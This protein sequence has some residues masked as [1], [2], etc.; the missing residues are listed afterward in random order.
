MFFDLDLPVGD[1][2]DPRSTAERLLMLQKC[3]FELKEKQYIC[4][5]VLNIVSNLL[6]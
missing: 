2:P 3:V 4:V 1:K 5:C 6:Q